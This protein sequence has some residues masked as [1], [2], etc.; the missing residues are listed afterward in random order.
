MRCYFL[1][2]LAMVGVTGGCQQNAAIMSRRDG[3]AIAE[4]HCRRW[5]QSCLWDA[6]TGG[7]LIRRKWEE[8]AGPLGLAPQRGDLDPWG[9]EYEFGYD[10]D[11]PLWFASSS[12]PDRRAGTEDDIIMVMLWSDPVVRRVRAF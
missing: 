12:G 3:D 9:E 1:G 6:N 10:T 2:L 5:L 8:D 11:P 4:Q 7:E